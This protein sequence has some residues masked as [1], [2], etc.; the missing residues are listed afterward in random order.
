MQQAKNLGTYSLRVWEPAYVAGIVAATTMGKETKFGFLGARPG[1]PILWTVNA[2]ALGARSV[3]PNVTVDLVFTN[4]WN[5]PAAETEAV[6]SLATQGVKGVYVLV[7]SPIA[8]VQAAERAGI[9]SLAHFADLS[10]FAPKGWITGSAWLWGKL[11][12]DVT[13][14]VLDKTWKPVHYGGGFAEGYVA[15]APYGPSVPPPAR[16][17]ADKVIGEIVAGQRDVFARADKRLGRD[18]QDSGG[19]DNVNRCDSRLRLDRRRGAARRWAL[20]R[21]L[22]GARLMGSLAQL[23]PLDDLEA[24]LWRT[25]VVSGSRQ[26][27]Y[28]SADSSRL[29]TT[30][31][32]WME[33]ESW[34]S[35]SSARGIISRLL[36]DPSARGHDVVRQVCQREPR[37]SSGVF[38][39]AE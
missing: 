17:A 35:A 18:G 13:K 34:T 12:Q 30:A 32:R 16:A 1:H 11:Y 19:T 5:D 33:N 39:D 28:R 2:F 8:A 37:I 14:Q 15:L 25:V 4:S 9:R 31:R 10:S 20:S 38:A 6:N 26:A 23:D 3:N 36:R 7:D 24:R 27:D 21:S 22:V 29:D